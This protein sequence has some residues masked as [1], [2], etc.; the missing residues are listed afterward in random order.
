LRIAPVSISATARPQAG[1]TRPVMS[2]PSTATP[3]LTK[4]DPGAERQSDRPALPA[5]KAERNAWRG[6]RGTTSTAEWLAAR[7]SWMAARD[8][9]HAGRAAPVRSLPQPSLAPTTG[10]G[11]GALVTSPVSPPAVDTAGQS[12]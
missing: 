9:A 8:L 3:D 1:L 2:E 11:A 6:T 12:V 10:A 5:W 4:V 7:A